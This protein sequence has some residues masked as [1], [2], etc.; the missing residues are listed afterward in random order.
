MTFDALAEIRKYSPERRPLLK[1]GCER[2][3]YNRWWNK[4]LRRGLAQ[5]GYT[6]ALA[7]D[8]D[9]NVLGTFDARLESVVRQ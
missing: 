3:P 6:G 9:S 4:L 1:L 2:E 5:L 8:G 7:L